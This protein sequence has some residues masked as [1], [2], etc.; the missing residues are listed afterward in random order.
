MDRKLT[1]LSL[2]GNSF[3]GDFL[4]LR[5]LLRLYA[6][7]CRV[8]DFF[9]N[10]DTKETNEIRSMLHQASGLETNGSDWVGLEGFLPEEFLDNPDGK[11]RYLLL[12]PFDYIF[13]IRWSTKKCRQLLAGYTHVI[14]PNAYWETKIEKNLKN[15]NIRI[16]KNLG[17]PFF[18]SMGIPEFA[19]KNRKKLQ[20]D[21]P[22]LEGK[23]IIYACFNG[24]RKNPDRNDYTE[25]DMQ[26][27]LDSLPVDHVLVTN[28]MNLRFACWHLDSGYRNRFI[29]I[30]GSFDML[31]L[32][33][34]ADYLLSNVAYCCAVFASTGRP[35][36][37]I[38]LNDNNFEKYVLHRYRDSLITNSREMA[39]TIKNM[40]SG[41][42]RCPVMEELQIN[43]GRS[44]VKELLG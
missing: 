11:K 16:V 3:K 39:M 24:Q 13:G 27:L 25:V 14:V 12:E 37:P 1:L 15:Q 5:K 44:L 29:Y 18:D 8:E 9:G 2:H 40:I 23:K 22:Q 28:S 31:E 17:F 38:Q 36:A 26:A 43:R 6:P 41:V 30:K 34:C 32:L 21:F 19:E 33:V 35:Y 42:Y 10:L 7:E 4:C 20:W